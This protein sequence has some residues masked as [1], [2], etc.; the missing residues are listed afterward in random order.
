MVQNDGVT[1]EEQ[2]LS[3]HDAAALCSVHGRPGR[4]WK[5]D[6]GVRRPWLAVKDP[7]TPKVPA[8]PDAVERQSEAALPQAIG[9]RAG[10]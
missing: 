1:S 9:S 5:I 2:V 3:Q 10:E 4:R 7:A 6:S 8:C